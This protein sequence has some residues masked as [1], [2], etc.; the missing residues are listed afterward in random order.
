M[1]LTRSFQ[2]HPALFN[3][4]PLVNVIFLVLVF[5]ALSSRFVL[6]PGMAVS[7]PVSAF[8][9]G[10]QMDAK[11]VSVTAAPVPTIYFLDQKMT[12]EELRQQL[13]AHRGRERSLIVKAD[14]GTPYDLVM[15]IMNEGLKLGFSVVLATGAE[16]P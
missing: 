15:Q 8:T 11:I 5:F 1:K 7:L 10:P 3:V 6:Q 4:I 2:I 12:L 16:R 13:T 14:R 9:L